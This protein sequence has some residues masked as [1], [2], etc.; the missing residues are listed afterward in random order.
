MGTHAPSV[1]VVRP[2]RASARRRQTA[3]K[4]GQRAALYTRVST[5]DQALEGFSLPAQLDALRSYARARGYVVAGEF[6]DEGKSA[7]KANRPQY[8]AMMA[9]RDSWDLVVVVKMDRIHRNARNFAEMMGELQESS[10]DF[11]SIQE[12]WDTSTAMG[13]STMDIVQRLAQLESE[14]TGERTHFGMEEKAKQGQGRLG[15][16]TPYGYRLTTVGLVPEPLEAVVVRRI[17]QAYADGV[18]LQKI[19]DE[20][21]L[22]GI[23]GRVWEPTQLRRMLQNPVYA[24]HTQWES[25]LRR[26]TH[27]ALVDVGVLAAVTDRLERTSR[28]SVAVSR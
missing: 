27:E 25:L 13:R 28:K 5:E 7:R 2:R 22:E 3:P 10:K 14:Q 12:S 8:Q 21:D 11:V 9:A 1:E 18:G 15:A 4:A 6:V 19:A 23:Q 16:P 20:L 26:N 17:F 24:G